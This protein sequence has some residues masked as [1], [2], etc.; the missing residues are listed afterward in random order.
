MLRLIKPTVAHVSAIHALIA[1]HVRSER[2]LPRSP[3]QIAERLR[4]YTLAVEHGEVIGVASLSL[5]D[6]YLAEVGVL[7][8][9][10]SDVE[11]E[12]LIAIL[13]EAQAMGVDRA[14]ILTDDPAPFEER[15]F[16]RTTLNALPEKRDRQCLRC[17]RAPRCRQQALT[18]QL[19]GQLAL[20]AR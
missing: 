9:D 2:L 10:R 5:V 15:G 1:P 17:S 6:T 11:G 13:D 19:Q 3:R 14:F 16:E 4:D 20:A 12:L 8:A 18:I 7:V